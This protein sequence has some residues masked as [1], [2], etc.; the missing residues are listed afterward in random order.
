MYVLRNVYIS[1]DSIDQSTDSLK[2]KVFSE[3]EKNQSEIVLLVA[4]NGCN[5]YFCYKF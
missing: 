1:D 2:F 4:L 5:I 3:E